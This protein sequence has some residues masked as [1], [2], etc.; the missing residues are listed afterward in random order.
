MLK[1]II[2]AFAVLSCVFLVM[3]GS[4]F[5]RSQAETVIR[6]R[7][8]GQPYRFAAF[9]TLFVF[10]VVLGA[11]GDHFLTALHAVRECLSNG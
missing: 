11:F 3:E 1:L 7:R 8:E 6:R 9:A 2:A 10:C 4:H 5:V